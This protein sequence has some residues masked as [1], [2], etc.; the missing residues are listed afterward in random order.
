M[1]QSLL[2][3]GSRSRREVCGR[4]GVDEF[5]DRSDLD[6][7][8]GTELEDEYGFGAERKGLAVKPRLHMGS[9]NRQFLHNSCECP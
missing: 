2:R 7:V 4:L 5:L 3:S 1:S 8:P 9:T 6:V